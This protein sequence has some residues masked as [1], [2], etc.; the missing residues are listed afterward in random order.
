MDASGHGRG[1][2]VLHA[3]HDFLPRHRA[4]SEIYAAQLCR[5]LSARHH[6]TIVCADY[7]P[8]RAHGHLTWRLHEGVPVVEITNNWVSAT[9]EETYRSPL[10]SARLEQVLDIV[11]PHIVHVHNLLNLSF[12][13]PAAARARG[14]PVVATLHDYTLVC[15]SGGQRIHRAES[16]VCHTIDT[17]RCA[18][19]FPESPFHTQAAIGPLAAAVAGSGRLQRVVAAVRRV[20]PGLL[21]AAARTV[22]DARR[23]PVTEADIDRRLSSARTVFDQVDLFVAPSRSLAREFVALGLDSSK[24]RVS[25]YGFPHMSRPARPPSGTRLRMGFVGTL[26]WHKGAHVL[27]DA[28]RRLPKDKYEVQIHGDPQVFPGY[29]ADLRRRAEGLPVRFMGR[30]EGTEASAVYREFDVLVVPSLWLE[31]S[32]L[33]IHE[34]FQ[35]GVPVVGARMGGIADLVTDGRNGRLYDAAS[36]QELAAILQSLIDN[37]AQLAQWAAAVPPVKTIGDDAREWERAYAEVIGAC[38]AEAEGEGG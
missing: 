6:V 31:N 19:C 13:L 9:F 38:R 20:S 27:L 12:D 23:F 2:R 26:A 36:P 5:E 21:R 18:R 10:M 8:A 15:P 22:G 24:V 33:V 3:I 30:F 14:I 34:A 1:L 35:A 28:V 25:D 11:Q 17:A 29:V 4:G 16:H 32:P 7:D 37:P